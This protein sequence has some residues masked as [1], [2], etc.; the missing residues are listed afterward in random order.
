MS[1]RS[2]LERIEYILTCARNILKFIAGM[3]LDAFMDDPRTSHAV[4]FEFTTMG[5]A[6][7]AMP[8]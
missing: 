1:P 8:A 5:G 2:W 4:A 7:R 6:A 3:D